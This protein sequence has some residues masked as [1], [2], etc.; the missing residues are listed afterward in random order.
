MR[1]A[2]HPVAGLS[3]QDVEV[4]V[5]KAEKNMMKEFQHLA[6]T[7]RSD[8]EKTAEEK[9]QRLVEELRVAKEEVQAAQTSARAAA[10]TLRDGPPPPKAPPPGL[11]ADV[12]LSEEV[13]ALAATV[14]EIVPGSNAAYADVGRMYPRRCK[15]CCVRY[16]S[17]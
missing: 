9:E 17:Q 11:P 5:L 12:A 14:G 6:D 2:D 15:R 4:Q 3:K 13:K 10:Q 8:A 16:G 1:E 7:A